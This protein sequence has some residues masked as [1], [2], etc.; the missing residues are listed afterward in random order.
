MLSLTRHDLVHLVLVG[1]VPIAITN[2]EPC[3]KVV[4][5]LLGA[6]QSITVLRASYRTSIDTTCEG[7]QPFD[8][9]ALLR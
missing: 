7:S 8:A 9:N 3:P 4:C 5:R 1:Y 2:S 6:S